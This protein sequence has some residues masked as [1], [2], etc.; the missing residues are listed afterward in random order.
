M[1]RTFEQ[2]DLDSV[3]DIWLSSNRDAHPF[4]P[5]AYWEENAATVK[6]QLPRAQVYVYEEGD[7]IAGF[8]GLNGDMVEGIFVAQGARSHGIGRQ[9]INYA[10]QTRKRLLLHVYAKNERALQFYRREGFVLREKTTDP[11]TGEAEY[12]MAWKRGL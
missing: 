5:A 7:R 9:L 8:I 4:I 10:K 11:L 1:I 6:E 3:M 12:I 2:R